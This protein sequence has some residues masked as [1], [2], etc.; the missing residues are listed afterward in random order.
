MIIHAVK[1]LLRT[2][3]NGSK[4]ILSKF[5]DNGSLDILVQVPD[6]YKSETDNIK[7]EIYD[8]TKSEFI[9]IIPMV[10]V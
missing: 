3:Y 5:D 9:K 4:I 6:E 10:E 7:V 1:R 2:K 8:L